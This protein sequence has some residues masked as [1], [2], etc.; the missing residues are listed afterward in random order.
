MFTNDNTGACKDTAHW[1]IPDSISL[2]G[3]SDFIS[4]TDEDWDY[5]CR[6]IFSVGDVGADNRAHPAGS[7]Y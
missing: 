5:S 6:Y 3:Y 2:E 7:Q 1:Y 4:E